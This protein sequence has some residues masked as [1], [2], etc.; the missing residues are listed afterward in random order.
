MSK[1]ALRELDGVLI[2]HPQ[3]VRII[4]ETQIM[5]LGNDLTNLINTMKEDKMLLNFSHV[6]FMGSAMI[7]KLILVSKKCKAARID[8][9]MCCLNENIIEVFRLMK[10]EKVFET[11]ANEPEAMKSFKE[12][13][14][15]WYV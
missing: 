9:R 5:E 10:M 2:V 13:K 3:D 8:M 11:Y 4:D 7:G 15:K 1:I 12:R 14:K 6:N